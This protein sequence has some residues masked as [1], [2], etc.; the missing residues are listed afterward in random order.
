MQ[1]WGDEVLKS[2]SMWEVALTSGLGQPREPYREESQPKSSE[3]TLELRLTHQ[4]EKAGVELTFQN[5]WKNQ[6]LPSWKEEP[7]KE[8]PI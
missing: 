7:V 1:I 5:F 2:E 3:E 6:T 8:L 4:E